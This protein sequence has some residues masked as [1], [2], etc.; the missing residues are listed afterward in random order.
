MAKQAYSTRQATKPSHL[1]RIL[2][3][4]G[5]AGLTL[6]VVAG[7]VVVVQLAASEIG[8]RAEA[9]PDPAPAHT[10]SVAVK[11]LKFEKAYTVRRSFVGQVEPQKTTSLSFE[12][13][14]RL[15]EVAAEEGD[16]VRK[17]QLL[18][19]QDVS[20][21]K[22]E[23]A[24]LVASKAATEA[25]L[26]FADQTVARN[27]KLTESGFTSQAG[28]DEALSRQ[29]ELR[30]RI[31]EID[32]RLD[33]VAIRIAKSELV[34]PFDGQITERLVDGSEAL[35]AGQRVFVLLE[36]RKPQ[37]RIGVAL[38]VTEAELTDAKIEV[39]GQEHPATL[40]ALRPDVDPVT[41][42]RTALF[43]LDTLDDPV[44]G[45]TARLVFFET[46][47]A[48]GV[49]L[50]TASLKEGAR[51]QWTVLTVDQDNTVR[52]A[53]VEILYADGDRVFA[54]GAFPE[55]TVLIDEGPHRVTVGQIVAVSDPS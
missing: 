34:S 45:Q 40:V 39:D 26:R 5:N 15:S 31:R 14:G 52:S 53:G 1:K 25:Q 51:G 36:L 16:F 18:A 6:V 35:G 8:R 37:V 11:P 13:P 9:A 33:N 54:R 41:R 55:G 30:A 7:A 44:F 50:P 38:D 32:A 23:Q 43:E 24:Q 21:L 12:L 47:A 2:K 48:D 3:A 49:W 46:V 17:G 10:I 27:S 28:L 42:T 4:A 29:S 20:L 19:R 22:S